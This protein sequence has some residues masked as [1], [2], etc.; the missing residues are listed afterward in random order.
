MAEAGVGDGRGG[1]C[2]SGERARAGPGVWWAGE[3]ALLAS[4]EALPGLS[5]P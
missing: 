2:P 4:P 1:L 3:T 5:L